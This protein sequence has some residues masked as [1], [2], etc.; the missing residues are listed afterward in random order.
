MVRT[1]LPSCVIFICLV[2][3]S[4]YETWLRPILKVTVFCWTP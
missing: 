1:V 2:F 4:T 3:A